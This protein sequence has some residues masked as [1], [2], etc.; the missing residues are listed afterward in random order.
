MIDLDGTDNKS[1]LGA[2]AVLGV[3]IATAKL[4]AAADGIF[5]WKYIADTAKTTPSLPK[6]Y[7]NVINGGAHADFRLPFQEYIVVPNDETISKAYARARAIMDNVGK[8]LKK[9]DGAVTMGDEGGYSLR[10]DTLDE[11]FDILTDSIAQ[12]GGGAFIAIDAAATELHRGG[13]Y[14]LLGSRY[15]AMSLSLA[16]KELIEKFNL[17]SIEDPFE[18]TDTKAFEAFYADVGDAV[19]VVGDDLTVTNPGIVAEMAERRAANAV[20]IKPNQIGTLLEVY[21]AVSIAKNAGWQIIVSHRSGETM[22]PFIADLAVGLGAFGIKAG[23]PTQPERVVKYER[24]L[25][26]ENEHGI[27]H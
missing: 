5:L 7:M 19:L 26:I 16:Y 6:L 10:L 1:V 25:A 14:E 3:S 9:K 2:N 4:I 23:A 15:S 13:A 22:D 18:E 12:A 27:I 11:P 20:I 21:D 24:L 8:E 17:R